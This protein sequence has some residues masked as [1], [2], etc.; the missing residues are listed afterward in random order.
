MKIS[1]IVPTYRRSRDLKRCLEALKYQSH[2]ADE[3]LVIVRNTDEETYSFLGNFLFESLPLKI[4]TIDHPGVIA[5]MNLGL[6]HVSG[7]IVAITDDD[8]EPHPDWL[9]KL[10]HHYVSDPQAGAVGGRDW[11]YFGDELQDGLN[12]PGASDVV[13]KLEWFGRMTGNHHIGQGDAREIDFLKGVNS[14]YRMSAIGNLR[15]DSRLL[16]LGAQVHHEAGFCLALKKKGWKIIY[17]PNCAVNHYPAS[18]F[19]GDQRNLFNFEACYHVAYNETF[20][21]NTYLDKHQFIIYFLW[22][23]LIGTRGCFGILQALRF[24]QLERDL[25][26]HKWLAATLG[27]LH[28]FYDLLFKARLVL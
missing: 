22:S 21:L 12:Y 18:R 4:L 7:D 8:A 24:I 26:L 16:G 10:Q 19:D 20:V 13:G 14:S 9:E 17:D 25:A 5:A 23:S 11:I 6:E 2:P 15:F 3:V 1:V 27:R 28:A